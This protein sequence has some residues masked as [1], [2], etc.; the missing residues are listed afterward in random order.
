[1]FAKGYTSIRAM[2][3]IQFGI[4]SQMITDIAYRYQLQLKDTEEENDILQYIAKE[5]QGERF[6]SFYKDKF[7][8]LLLTNRS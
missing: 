6:T 1:M 7:I 8:S 2:I 3:G 4:L 5:T